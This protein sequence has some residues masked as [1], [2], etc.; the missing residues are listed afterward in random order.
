MFVSTNYG[1][2]TE[3]FY[4][5][6]SK[7]QGI[8]YI[9]LDQLD[10]EVKLKEPYVL[11]AVFSMDSLQTILNRDIIFLDKRFRQI[12]QSEYLESMSSDYNFGYEVKYDMYI[13]AESYEIDGETYNAVACR[14]LNGRI[15]K[16]RR[17]LKRME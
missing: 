3:Y 17:K 14:H 7:F 2:T 6:D 5:V 12:S 9:P 4:W 1:D 11:K 16:L 15:K 10:Y 13:L 8:Q